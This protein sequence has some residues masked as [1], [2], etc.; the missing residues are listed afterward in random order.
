[1][2][3][4]HP[5][6]ALLLQVV[7]EELQGPVGPS[8]VMES[9]QLCYYVLGLVHS[10]WSPIPGALKDF[11]GSPKTNGYQSLHTTVVPLSILSKNCSL[12]PME[13][14]IRT[15]DMD[16]CVYGASPA[17]C[18]VRKHILCL[19]VEGRWGGWCVD[20]GIMQGVYACSLIWR[21]QTRHAS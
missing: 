18:C 3:H 19:F 17:V 9:H 14:Q 7:M 12:V 4:F 5:P 20:G 16:R 8:F 21:P 10:I 13:V 6:Y 11:I 15:A 2:V 1:M